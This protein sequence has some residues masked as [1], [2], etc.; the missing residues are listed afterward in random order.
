MADTPRDTEETDDGEDVTPWPDEKDQWMSS[1]QA[2]EFMLRHRDNDLKV[3]VNS[4][5]VP[6][7]GVIYDHLADSVVILLYDG[8]DLRVAMSPLLPVE[9]EE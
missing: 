5:N 1:H 8:E 4:T 6:V 7:R 3:T 2:A 9:D